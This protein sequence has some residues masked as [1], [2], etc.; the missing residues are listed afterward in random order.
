MV[1]Q[2]I[3]AN[4]NVL[5]PTVSQTGINIFTNGADT[6]TRGIDLTASYASDLFG[7]GRVNWTLSGNY[8]KTK[9]TKIGLAPA[10][11][12]PAGATQP[13]ALFDAGVISNLE[14]ASPRW[15]LIAGAFFTSGP[16]SV[17]LRETVYGKTAQD[18]SPD[19][20]TFYRQTVK[21]AGITDLQVNFKLTRS[22]E[23]SAGAN[24]LFN[25]RPPNYRVLPAAGGLTGTVVTGGNIYDSPLTS[26]PYGINGGYY[27]G[28]I[29]FSF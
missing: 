14:R 1:T 7:L 21:T 22:I 23:L 29:N 2:A 5:D 15:K 9:I 26:S 20:G 4:G 19:G 24:N 11:L 10:T 8:N 6:R 12:T 27:Y 17:T 13:I 25:K 16:L 28:R 18:V 3:I